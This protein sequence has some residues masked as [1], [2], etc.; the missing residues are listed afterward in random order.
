LPIALPF[1]RRPA[2]ISPWTDTQP[3]RAE[4]FGLERLEEHA[5]SLAA[6]QSVVDGSRGR[7]RLSARLVDNA[8]VLLG[9]YRSLAAAMDEQ[10]PVTAAAEWL[11]DNYHVVERQIRAIRSD[12][13][14]GYYRQLPKLTSGPFAGY[15]RVL[16]MAW[17]FVAHTDSHF[18]PQMMARFVRAYQQVQPLTIGELWAVSITLRF[19][20]IENLRRLAESITAQRAAQ[21]QADAMADRLLGHDGAAPE[22][23]G[24]V[25]ATVNDLPLAE[26]FAVQL[27]HRLRDQDPSITPAL[28]WLERRLADQGLASEGLVRDLHRAEGAANVT[29]RNI[30]TSLRLIGDIDWNQLVEGVSLVDAA[31]DAQGSF[32]RMDF[33]TRNLYRSAVEVLARRSGL[34]E[35]EVANR[36]MQATRRIHADPRRADAG[37]HLVAGGRP[38]FE[39]EI[40]FRTS[41]R[42]WPARLMVAAGITGYVATITTT[43][44]LLLA[45]PLAA[46][47]ASEHGLA[48]LLLFTVLGL[49]PAQD[50]AM[51]LVNRAVTSGFGAQ[52][53]PGMALAEGVPA[54]HRSI[55]V[56]PTLL[57]STAGIAEQVERLEVHFLASPP[58]ALHFA[59]LS[60]WMDAASERNA[61]DDTLLAAARAGIAALNERHGP[62]EGGARFLLLHRRRLWNEGEGRWMGWERK[63]GK[64]HE[65]NR[66]LRGASDTTFIAIDGSAA[67][68]PADVRFVITLDSDTRL[69]RDT[70]R[71]LIGKM[72]HP[73]NAPRLDRQA[74]RVVEGYAILQ[75]RVTP[76]LPVGNEGS[77]FQRVFSSLSGIDP[78][79]L[80]VSDVYQDL[81]GEGSYTGKGIYDIDAFEAALAGRVPESTLLSHD[82][83]EGAFARSGLASDVEVVEEFP[84]RYDVGAQRHHRW[85]RGD[86]QLLPWILGHGPR[87]E[88]GQG[89]AGNREASHREASHREASHREPVPAIGWWK[90]LDNL[91]RSLTPPATVLALLAGLALPAQGALGWTL[92][93]LASLAIPTLIPV[94]AAILPWR[95]GITFASHARALGRDLGTALALSALLVAFLAHQAWLMGD[96]ILRTLWRLFAS[97]RNLLQWKPSTLASDEPRLGLAGFYYAMWGAPVI[98]LLALL[99]GAM[100][101]HWVIGSVLGLAWIGSPAIALW[102]SLAPHGAGQLTMN[103]AQRQALRLIAR[104]TWRYF[105]QFVTPAD[106]ALPPDNFQEDPAPVLARRTSPTNV[107]LYL[108]A[109]VSARDFG[110]I[111]TAEAVGRVEDTLATL[112]RMQRHRGHFFNWYDTADL[113]PLEPRYV[114]SVDSGNLAGHLIALANACREWRLRHQPVPISGVHD[115]L[116]IARA[117]AGAP[118]AALL[119]VAAAA[120][121]HD[122]AGFARHAALAVEKAPG[123]EATFWINAAVASFDSR[124]RDALM[125]AEQRAAL[126]RRLAALEEA[127]RALA[128][129]MD[130]AFL[131]DHD[132]ELLSLGYLVAEA[133]LD[134]S[135]YDMLA[136]EARLA[137]F[138]AIAKCDAPARHWFRLGRNMTPVA[139]S[140]A[141]VS[142]SGSM[143]EYLMPSL[144]MRAPGGSLL[145]QTNRLSVQRQ[146]EY[147]ESLGL[148]WGISESA[149]NARDLELTY[150]YANFGVPS[151]GLK[152]GLSE[153][154]VVAPYATALAAMIDPAAACVNF[155]RLAAEG[156]QGRYGFYE[157]ID[158]TPARLPKGARHVVVRAFMAH[159]Q[160]MT[161]VAIADALSGG[162]MRQRFHAEP[163]VQATEL[164]LQERVPREVAVAHH[165]AAEVRTAR[166]IFAEEQA[167]QRRLTSAQQAVPATHLLSN[168]SFTTQLTA[169]GSGSLRWRGLAVTRWREDATCDDLGAYILLRDVRTGA[170]WSA[171]TQP[172]GC[173][174]DA[175]VIS[176]NE[177]RAEFLRQEG[178]IATQLEIIVSAEDDGEVRRLSITNNGT[179]TCE[180]EVTSYAELVLARQADDMAHPAFS[181]LFVQTEY[182]PEPGI[183]LATRRPRGPE[184]PSIWAAHFAVVEGDTIGPQ[185]VE[186]DRARFIGRGRTLRDPAAMAPGALLSNSVGN[187]LD[188]IF[189]LRRRLRIPPAGVARLAFWTMVAPTRE[190][191]LNGADRHRDV[192]AFARAATLAWTQAQVQLRHLG[193]TPGRAALYQR[194]AGHVVHATPKL[195]ASSEAI[196]R[197]TGPQS[198]L[199]S[200]GI[201]GDLPIVLLRIAEIEHLDVARDLLQAFAYWRGKQLAVDL[202]I[203]NDHHASYIQDLQGALE[204]LIRVNRSGQNG[205]LGHV[206]PLRADLLPA[207]TVAQLL[208]AA[209]VVILGR[210][211]SLLDQVNKAPAGRLMPGT[212]PRRRAVAQPAPVAPPQ[213]APALELFNGFGGFD[214]DGRDYVTLLAPGVTTPAPWVNVIAN[215]HFGFHVAA[216]GGGFTWAMNSRENQITPWSNDPVADRPGEAFYL[217]DEETGVVWSPTASPIRDPAG[218]YRARHGRGFSSFEHEAQ[219][220]QATLTQSVPLSDCA[221]ISRLVL[222]NRS[223]RARKLSVTAYVEWVLGPSRGASLGHV[224]TAI[225]AE[226]GAMFARNPWSLAFGGR[227]AFLDLGGTQGEWTADRREFIGRNASLADPAGM[228]SLVPLSKTVGGGL[229]PCGAMRRDI[230]LPADGRIEVVCFLGQAADDAAAR[231][232]LTRLRAADLDA[233]ARDV[234]AYWEDVLGRVQ[235]RT[236]DRAMDIMLNGWLLYQALACRIW[237]RAGFYQASGA[238]GFRDQL[239]DG[240]ALVT[241]RPAMTREHLLRA[242]SRQFVEGDVQHWW[243]PHSGQGVRTRISDDRGWLA[244]AVDHYVASTGDVAIL[245]EQVAFLDGAVL[246][247]GE[248]ERFF[249]PGRA[250]DT[251]TLFEHCAR[252]LDQ[253]LAVGRHGL[254]LIGTG[255]WNDGMNR[256]GEHGEGESVWLGWML[257][258]ALTA[259][260]PRAAARGDAAH[261]EAWLAHAETLRLALEA[262]GWDGDWYRRGFY[263]DGTKLGSAEAAEC[264]IDSIAQSW[265]VLSGAAVPARARQAMDSAARELIRPEEGLALL[266]APPFDRTGQDPGY[267]KAYPPGIRENGGQYT[268]AGLWL[269]MAFAALG[270]GSK[271]AGLFAL[272]N[273]INHART[274]AEALRYRVEPYVVAADIQ[275]TA[276]HVGRGGWTW[277][278]GSS[279]WMQ[280]AGVESILGLRLKAGVLHFNPC[281]PATWPGFAVTLR[282]HSARYEISVTNPHCVERG[283]VSAVLDGVQLGAGPLRLPLVDDGAVHVLV[284][285]LGR[286]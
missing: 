179:T 48:V 137:S 160:G 83:F 89:E 2:A 161:V 28:A 190:A 255:D 44:L 27:V 191:V 122:Q 283:I 29:V 148:P 113:R 71:R 68:V 13:P 136:S 9:C 41:L 277:Y 260:A 141:L 120:T 184:E 152:R 128:L 104:R 243:L 271:A 158:Y 127:A 155:Q 267:I 204:A 73:L 174:P 228:A 216:E 162:R 221:K 226:T 178:F 168:G 206:Y 207:G 131:L 30:I 192:T 6:A 51:A 266:F 285:T 143:F 4:I 254:P 98:G 15:P 133:K 211:G 74:G 121:A 49:L 200:Q 231:A 55:I 220:I 159:H 25:L 146:I 86:W 229:D 87:R 233:V 107:G 208:A 194:L 91:R 43:T 282:H 117:E 50:L 5:R 130:F 24:A 7:N 99:I 256:V 75:P 85:A 8:A 103:A 95:P 78:Y 26:G 59:L 215:P 139:E 227:V 237:A 279:G 11:I 94:I 173:A 276:P 54:D 60:D 72:A 32:R 177:D 140:A 118:E 100:S 280:R 249:L 93:I 278:T 33:A 212:P 42:A 38:A 80:T 35:I 171:T 222:V 286:G 115:A 262:E 193:I 224:I 213:P 129:A 17:A 164:L 147:G 67:R 57:S 209:R 102:A 123:E 134:P 37:Y 196:C 248:H 238:Y 275:S 257:H 264:R 56:I 88:A 119:A 186:T 47:G 185:Q 36:A 65:L 19:V 239:Q 34:S 145:A 265:A 64:L 205:H 234:A 21:S 106:N 214:R 153:N 163:L 66:L 252:A 46:T 183:L 142:W 22:P 281:I 58:G 245:D 176:F 112:A 116:D 169:A 144:V 96:A 62:V 258:V 182:L 250:E 111:G 45:L 244:L 242:A 197:G 70:V 157:A 166:A 84:P 175:C 273:P 124:Q 77:F 268:H 217:R 201:S 180:I 274:Q 263:D 165:W 105:E 23:L 108:L 202:V 181:K 188:P 10:R 218:H 219:G 135:C 53:L 203:L 253:S 284:A 232:M 210:R 150:Q 39:A 235:V 1:Q 110:W 109:V 97:H 82:L 18:N 20:L 31:L 225:D 61:A 92:F 198:G 125:T 132:R 52:L 63:R 236:P 246:A 269:V 270:E 223:G 199:W 16:G 189:A 149:Y 154:V 170:V 126:Q 247:P 69:P 230:L 114:S 14:P 187:V 138:F 259:F 240:M 195:R 172:M 90:M 241:A 81:F 261:A 272:L 40:G 76:S 12:L 167:G 251:A 3:A 79:A 101:G 156:A 151:L